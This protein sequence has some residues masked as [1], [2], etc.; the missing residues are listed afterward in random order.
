MSEND[1][2]TL[3]C[4]IDGKDRPFHLKANRNWAIAEL[5]DSVRER[6]SDLCAGIN[7]IF[8]WKVSVL[9]VN[10]NVPANFFSQV[11]KPSSVD[12]E[13]DF[14]DRFPCPILD[15][16]DKAIVTRLNLRTLPVSDAFP[17]LA[18]GQLHIVMEVRK[19][20]ECAYIVILM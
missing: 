13:E 1:V 8:L 18:K 2:W 10:E 3:W 20:G 5:A 19:P 17:E 6:R 14:C 11:T 7:D 4:L 9:L 16:A 15:F 12:P